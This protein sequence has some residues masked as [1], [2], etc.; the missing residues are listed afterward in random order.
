MAYQRINSFTFGSLELREPPK[1]WGI[2]EETIPTVLIFSCLWSDD[3][4][5]D[6]VGPLVYFLIALFRR[7]SHQRC[8]SQPYQLCF[9]HI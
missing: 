9:Q 8:W 3:K 1:W 6:I 7:I 2:L 4:L 5:Q